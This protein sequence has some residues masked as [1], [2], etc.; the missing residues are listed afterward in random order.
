MLESGQTY[1]ETIYLL[2][3]KKDK[4]RAIDV[5]KELGFAKPS[6]SRAI[7]KLK[8]EGVLVDGESLDLVLTKEGLSQAKKLVEKQ[9]LCA[10]FLMMTTDVDEATAKVDGK[11]MMHFI[12]D[13][14]FKGIKKFI[15]E[16]ESMND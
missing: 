14:T 4:V 16:V 8:K 2:S 11:K 9:E 1:L 6:V 5:A 10:Q 7:G 3:L 15:K 13:K 12:S